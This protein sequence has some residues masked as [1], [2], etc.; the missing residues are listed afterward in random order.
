MQTTIKIHGAF[1]IARALNA[2]PGKLTD[3][4]LLEKAMR[5]GAVLVRDEARN[6]VPVLKEPHPNR[7]SGTLRRA[8]QVSR[9]RPE[10]G[11]RAVILVRIRPLTKGQIRKFVKSRLGKARNVTGG[12][13]PYDP[14]YWRFVEFGTS[15]MAARPFMRPAFESK[16][17]AAVHKSIEQLRG[18]VAAELMK[19]RVRGWRGA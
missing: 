1:E 5:S 7:I 16:K 8:I 9:G 3:K 11:A 17:V 13:N 2:L 4:K 14:F 15:K 12:D 18:L 6:R 19:M 10:K